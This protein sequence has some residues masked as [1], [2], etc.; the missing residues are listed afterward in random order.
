M[1]QVFPE[2]KAKKLKD[3]CRTR[4]VE[5]IDSYSVFLDLLPAVHRTLL[6]MVN[7][8]EFPDLGTNWAWDGE[9]ITKANGFLHQLHS[10]SF[11]I[12]VKVLLEVMCCLRGLTKKLQ[13]QA[14]DVFYAYKQITSVLST[15][16]SM[17]VNSD[18]EFHK[19]FD[20]ATRLGKN[21]HGEDYVF[22]LPRITER[23][24]HRS[25]PQV[26]N[27]EEY[28]RITLYNEF[29]SQVVAEIEKRFTENP[30]HGIGILNLLPVECC[31]HQVEDSMP[32][33]LKQAV[34][35]YQSD[36]SQPSMLPVEYRAW[37]R[38]W[39]HKDGNELPC[40]L[41]DVLQACDITSFPNIH[42]LLTIA[43]TLPITSCESERS[44]SQLKL[45]KTSRRSTM[46]SERLSGLALM[47]VNRKHCQ[48]LH[49]SPEK[50]NEMV[51]MFTQ[52]NPRRMK[53]PFLLHD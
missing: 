39:K 49:D 17:R 34:D 4:W 10:S 6:A 35:F 52:A 38:A 15:L 29:L 53:L 47:K 27:P 50:L 46:T 48:H 31:K 41:V 18:R 42:Q 37:V 33:E 23:Q 32:L 1:E 16:K 8:N 28:Y 19:I 14:I 40:K 5:R 11:L 36:L 2:A 30:V 20:E 43:L 21:L 45:I 44:F 12:S 26:S 13:L 51:R 24:S 9:T 3:A 22:C 25:N 7:P